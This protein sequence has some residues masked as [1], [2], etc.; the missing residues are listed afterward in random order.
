ML[1]CSSTPAK[2][3][4]PALSPQTAASLLQFDNKAKNW[5]EYV[6]RKDPTCEYKVDLPDQANQPTEIDLDHVIL[7]GG[8]PSPKEFDASVVFS[9]DKTQQRW[10]LTRFSS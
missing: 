7:C 8:R 10:V 4:V 9:Y 1:A 2:P 5:I 3:D 6:K